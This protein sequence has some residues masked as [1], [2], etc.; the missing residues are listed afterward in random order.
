VTHRDRTEAER[1]LQRW[2]SRSLEQLFDDLAQ[3]GRR[4]REGEELRV[5]R[6]TVLLRSG[7]EL[8]GFVL[9]VHGDRAGGRTVL[10][11]S[12]A[13]AHPSG[14][15]V[16]H[17]PWATIDALTVHD[18]A[19]WDKPPADAPPP[20]TK[21][22]L[23]N[24]A[25]LASEAIAEKVGTPIAI[26]LELGD[27]DAALEPLDWLLRQVRAALLDVASTPSSADAM[28]GRVKQVRLTVG[29][30][31]LT[32]FADGAL[33]ITTPLSWNKRAS[34]DGLRRELAALL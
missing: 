6:V 14:V 18:I 24:R 23:L 21:E 5:P 9:D 19:S 12:P 27:D 29:I 31:P 33:V 28:R 4:W 10:V 15:D 30:Q 11:R 1:S 3:L 22:E 13:A 34:P 2:P 7:L 32:A 20:P 26:E 25:S 16:T 17:V 8:T